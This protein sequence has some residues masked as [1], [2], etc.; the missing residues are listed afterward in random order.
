VLVD[1]QTPPR[2]APP[3]VAPYDNGPICYAH[4]IIN[5]MLS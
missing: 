1:H 4:A 5:Y 2:L 3:A